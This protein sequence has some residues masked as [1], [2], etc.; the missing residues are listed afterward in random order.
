MIFKRF[1]VGNGRSFHLCQWIVQRQNLRH[2]SG[3]DLRLEV[4]S[5][6]A[7]VT[8]AAQEEGNIE[9]LREEKR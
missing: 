1:A 8:D 9:E 3:T 6:N 7:A 5:A 4:P 2:S